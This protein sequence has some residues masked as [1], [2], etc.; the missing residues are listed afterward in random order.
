MPKFLILWDND[1]YS[2]VVEAD[3]QA[4]ADEAGYQLWKEW[5]ENQ[6][7]HHAQLLTQ[8]LAEN[9]GHEDEFDEANTSKG[10]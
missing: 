10:S 9:Y 6:A 5:A 7:D 3:N 2:E 8:E 1:T 4:E